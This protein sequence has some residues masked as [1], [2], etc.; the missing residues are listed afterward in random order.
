LKD[1]L[2]NGSKLNITYTGVS[3]NAGTQNGWFIRE[4]PSINGWSGGSPILGNHHRHEVLICVWKSLLPAGS[5]KSIGV[6]MEHPLSL[7]R[8]ITP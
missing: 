8:K 6:A 1:I 7:N 5:S 3:I 4:N 2:K